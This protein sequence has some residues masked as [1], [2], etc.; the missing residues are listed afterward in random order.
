V[1]V[2]ARVELVRES[3]SS[4]ALRGRWY[5]VLNAHAPRKK[6]FPLGI[7]QVIEH[8]PKCY[9]KIPMENF[10]AKLEREEIFKTRIGNDNMGIVMTMVTEWLNLTHQKTWLLIA[11]CS[12]TETII[13]TPGPF[14]MKRYNHNEQVMVER[15][16]HSSLLDVQSFRKADCNSKH[17]LAVAKV[18]DRVSARGGADK[19]LARPTSRCPR[20]ES[21][22]SFEIVR[23][24]NCTSFL[25]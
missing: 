5:I 17:C 14:L 20:T 12:R 3:M 15:R 11:R 22:V 8:I 19:S 24:P 23:V 6:E 2:G 25:L 18:W 21:K 9:R 13:N 7:R 10:N 4:L 1:P 16:L